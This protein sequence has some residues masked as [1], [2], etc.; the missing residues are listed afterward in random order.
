MVHFAF[1]KCLQKDVSSSKPCVY[2]VALLLLGL[3]FFISLFLAFFPPS[4]SVSPSLLV[5]VLHA[6]ELSTQDRGW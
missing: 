1:T 6:I 2:Y 4:V 3:S 5:S